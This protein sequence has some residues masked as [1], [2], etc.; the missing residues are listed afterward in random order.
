MCRLTCF[1][2]T[3]LTLQ[4]VWSQAAL[5]Q[6]A[7]P[8]SHMV[9]DDRFAGDII[10]NEVRVPKAGEATYTYYETLGWRGQGGGYAGIQAHPKAHNFI[11]SI[12]DHKAHTAPIKAVHRGPGTETLGF[13]GEG[14]GLKSWNFELGWNVDVW[15]ALAAR[16]WPVGDH[17]HFGF[18]VRAGDTGKWT[19]LVTM[20][21]AASASFEGGTDAFLEDWLDTGKDCRAV[22]LRNGWKRKTDG[23]WFPFGQSHYSVNSWDLE[24]GKRSYNYRTN[25]NGGV[26]SDA[27]GQYYFMQS[28]GADTVATTDNPSNFSIERT[29]TEPAFDVIKVQSAKLTQRDDDSLVVSWEVDDTTT[30]P[31]AYEIELFADEAADAKPLAQIADRIPHARS[32]VI[33]LSSL[34]VDVTKCRVRLRLTDIFDRK[35]EA[36][37]LTLS[38]AVK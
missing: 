8:S 19:H 32:A 27:T 12:W 38:V 13:G 36:K 20:D 4:G 30:P 10:V 34:N 9:F 26:Q 23:T 31:F 22:N 17:T 14:T 37:T 5:A 25:W 18:W 6:K 1:V 35:S 16:T 29:E 7:A 21:V 28:G 2:L 15:Y 3:L 24:P 11:F 33:D